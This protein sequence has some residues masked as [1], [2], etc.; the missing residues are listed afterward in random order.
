MKLIAKIKR[1]RGPIWRAGKAIKGA[2]T[3][4]HLPIGIARPIFS[5]M[6]ELHMLAEVA[7]V[8]CIRF[9]Y[10]EPMFRSKC[11]QIGKRFKM[12]HLPYLTG[13]GSICIGD[14]VRLSGKSA[15]AFSNQIRVAPSLLIGNGVFIG[16]EC[17]LHIATALEIGDNTLIAKGVTIYDFDGHPYAANER[18]EEQQIE[19]SNCAQVRIG[20]DVWIGSKAIILKGVTIGDGAIVAAGSVVTRDVE[21]RTVVAGNPAKLVKRLDRESGPSVPS[22]HLT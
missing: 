18:R 13:F 22:G 14:N 16:H 6:Y 9:L 17:G 12:E 5:L 2:V 11:S 1:E 19:D 7:A 8:S 3:E 20:K 21:A 15:I 10:T 4:V